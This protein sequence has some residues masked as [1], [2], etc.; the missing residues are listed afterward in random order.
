MGQELEREALLGRVGK[1]DRVLIEELDENGV[2]V[3]YSDGYMRVR[4]PGTQAGDIVRVR[5][6]DVE[7]DELKGEVL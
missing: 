5:I 7:K 3:G 4:V 2:G 1:E 6:T